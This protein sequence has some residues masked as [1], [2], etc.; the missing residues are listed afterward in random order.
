MSDFGLDEGDVRKSRV[1]AQCGAAYS[2]AEYVSSSPH[3]F[4][5]LSLLKIQ[6]GAIEDRDKQRGASPIL[7]GSTFVA[8][9][10]AANLR[11]G[12]YVVACTG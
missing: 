11:E 10:Q 4:R 2:I 6:F 8:M 9:M 3:Y 12:N 5:S 7:R 1:C